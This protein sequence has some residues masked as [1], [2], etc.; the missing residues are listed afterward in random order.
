MEQLVSSNFKLG[1]IS[2]GQL[3]KMLIQEA[4]KWDVCTYVLDK[5]ENCPSR[6]LA[7]HYI[8]GS[9][10]DYDAVYE[11]GKKVDLLTFE[12]ENVN[13]KA[14]KKLK[15]EGKKIIPDPSIL[16]LIQ[17]KGKQKAFFEQ[18]QIPTSTFKMYASVQA[19]KEAV[20]QKELKFP[21]VQKVREGGYDGRGVAVINS[22]DKLEKLLDGPSIVE[23]K[24]EIDKELAVI[25]ARN[26]HGEIKSYPVVEMVFDPEANL[27]DMLVSP[28]T[29]SEELAAKTT[30][31]ANKIIGK[32]NMQGLLAIEFFLDTKG[33]IVVNEMAPRTHNSGHQTIESMETSQFEQH[34]RSIFNL[35]LGSTMQT[36]PAVMLNVLGAA[37][38]EGPVQYKGLTQ[39]MEIEGANIHLYGKKIT[40]PFRKMG[41]ITL[42]APT[43]E[44]AIEN[45]EKAKNL[46]KVEA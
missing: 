3:G 23:E 35:K 14:L 13:I 19:I 7:N 17:D 27:V 22:P 39:L 1:I 12:I 31:L 30:Q 40:K 29:I 33:Q 34:L 32:L 24:V 10:T 36:Q 15:E 45:A 16:E 5:D 21:F 38:F 6:V 20:E 41:H 9:N 26:A 4:S 8:Q 2:G 11:F 37:G 46:I 42:V 25:V 43:M 44:Q 18:H 28:A